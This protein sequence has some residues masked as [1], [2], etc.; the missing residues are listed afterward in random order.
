MKNIQGRRKENLH[1]QMIPWSVVEK[2]AI[3]IFQ[4]THIHT[5]M[6]ACTHRNVV[7]DRN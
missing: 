1:N 4:K 6:H 5:C 7:G 2:E 3:S